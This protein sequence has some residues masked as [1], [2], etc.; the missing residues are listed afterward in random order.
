MPPPWAASMR[1]MVIAE[2]L[3]AWG[4]VRRVRRR[5]LVSVCSPPRLAF[6]YLIRLDRI[7]GHC[8]I[9]AVAAAARTPPAIAHGSEY[10]QLS[11]QVRQAGLMRR[12]PGYYTAK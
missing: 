9:R 8:L 6:G 7:H 4:R 10:A 2:T 11:R 1:S 3:P 12:R 5:E